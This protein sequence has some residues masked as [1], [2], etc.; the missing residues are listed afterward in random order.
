MLKA[1]YKLI[2]VFWYNYILIDI[3]IEV[4]IGFLQ[5]PNLIKFK[6]WS[7]L[8]VPIKYEQIYVSNATVPIVRELDT[9]LQSHLVVPVGQ[10]NLI[11]V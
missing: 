9:I 7:I 10:I 8:F 11:T 4:D 1:L 2:P 3:N 6:F 5:F